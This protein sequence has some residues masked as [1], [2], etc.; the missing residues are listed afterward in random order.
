MFKPNVFAQEL[1]QVSIN[2]ALLIMAT[3]WCVAS[4]RRMPV[5]SLPAYSMRL[6][7]MRK[8]DNM[9]NK[10]PEQKIT[11]ISIHIASLSASFKPTPD[12]RHATHWFTTDE[13]YDAIR[14]IDPGAQISKEQVHQAMLDAGYKYQNRP[15]SSGLDFRWMLQAKN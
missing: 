8:E 10:E 9:K 6:M 2:I 14:R 7:L 15:G 12:A 11:D 3:M 5:K 1:K 13:V 4:L